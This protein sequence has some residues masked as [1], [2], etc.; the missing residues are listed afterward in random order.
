MLAYG[1]CMHT[2]THT[3]LLTLTLTETHT[4]THTHTDAHLKNIYANTGCPC[5]PDHI[6]RKIFCWELLQGHICHSIWEADGDGWLGI[7]LWRTADM[8]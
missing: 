3:R 5:L 2:H 1:I 6:L 8:P 4:H 7:N